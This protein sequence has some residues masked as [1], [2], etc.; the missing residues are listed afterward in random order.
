MAPKPVNILI[1][2]PNISA[3]ELRDSNVWRTSIGGFL[4]AAASIAFANT[5]DGLKRNGTL[6]VFG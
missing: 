1:I 2:R 6:P 3:K 4:G 5:A